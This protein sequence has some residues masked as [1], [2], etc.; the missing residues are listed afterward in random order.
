MRIADKTVFGSAI[1]HHRYTK[2]Q[3]WNS[4]G[5]LVKL[6]ANPTAILD[7]KTFQFLRAINTPADTVWFNHDPTHLFAVNGTGKQVLRIDAVSGASTTLRTE[8]ECTRLDLGFGEGNISNDD[9][10]AVLICTKGASSY[11]FMLYDIPNNAIIATKDVT[12]TSDLDWISVSPSGKYIMANWRTYGTGQYNGV[13]L[14]DQNFN[15][16]RQIY[17]EDQHGDMGYDGNGREIYV[18]YDDNISVIAFDLAGG[19]QR[20]VMNQNVQ[21]NISC[22]NID[23]PGWCYVTPDIKLD[24]TLYDEVFALKLDG[25]MTV[26]R[27]ANHHSSLYTYDAAPLGTPNRDG[28]YVMFA[29]DWETQTTPIYSYVAWMS[30]SGQ[31]PSPVPPTPTLTNTPTPTPTPGGPTFTTSP[32][33]TSP[34]GS[35]TAF[36][37]NVTSPAVDDWIGVYVPGTLNNAYLNW[38][39]TSSCSQSTG[40]IAKSSGNCTITM[41]PTPGTYELRLF[42]INSHIVPVA[43]SP[44]ITVTNMSPSATPTPANS[45]APTSVPTPTPSS[46]DTTPPTVTITSPVN[47][48]TVSRHSNVTITTSA[49]D[50]VGVTKVEFYIN[51]TLK[52]TDTTS[53]YSYVWSVPN[54]RNVQYTLTAKAYDTVG[55]NSSNSVNVTAK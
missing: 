4:D 5:T 42:A 44:A 38:L 30:Y 7:G 40:T 13:E 37:N 6:Q 54:S 47:G 33:T 16:I 34:G 24:G 39:Y 25:S 35:I 46:S 22:R 19:S 43:T 18:Q 10:Y 27:F 48:G 26:E 32:T 29:S 3:A 28:T 14:Y 9:R 12:T 11:T 8:S 55:N 20:T 51:N 52:F 31:T 21:G 36:W 15:F 23:R 50:N 2:D 1:T 49:S 45:P 41:P 53:P 17:Y